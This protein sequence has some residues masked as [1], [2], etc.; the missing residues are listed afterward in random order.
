MKEGLTLPQAI[1]APSA[2]IENTRQLGVDCQPLA[3]TTAGHVAANLRRSTCTRA[4]FFIGFYLK[5]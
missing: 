1:P 3:Q 2:E 5:R 4:R